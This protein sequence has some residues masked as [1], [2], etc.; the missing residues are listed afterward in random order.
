MSIQILDIYRGNYFEPEREINTGTDAVLIKAG[1]GGYQDYL[2]NRC[3]YIDF[4]DHVGLPWGVYWQMDARHSPE[5]HKAALKHFFDKLG[6]GALGLWLACEKPYYPCPD[7]IYSR[8]PYAFYKPIESVW[9]GLQPYSGAWP[10]IYTSPGMWSLIFGRC[11]LPLQQEIAAN[12]K[13]W[14]AQYKVDRPARIGAWPGYWFWQYMAEPDYS[15][16]AGSEEEFQELYGRV[17]IPK[18]PPVIT[19]APAPAADRLAVLNEAIAAVE[20]LK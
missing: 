16:F 14:A 5:E 13:L 17:D 12:S 9:R 18:P 3:I 2:D 20:A 19:P 15:V 1:Q 10:G 11:P 7:F 8:M 6:F 4:C